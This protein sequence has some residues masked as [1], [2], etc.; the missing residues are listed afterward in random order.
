[1]HRIFLWWG[2]IFFVSLVIPVKIYASDIVLNEIFANPVNENDE[3]VELYNKSDNEIDLAGWK[4]SD[5]VK[6]YTL[7]D[8]KISPKGFLVLEKSLTGITLNNSDETVSILDNV[9]NVVDTF[10]YEDT[11]EGKTWSRVP[12]GIGDFVNNT[13]ITKGFQNAMPPTSTPSPSPTP[14]K[15]PKPTKS[16]TATKIPTSTPQPVISKIENENIDD[17]TPEP[18]IR[19]SSIPIVS[20]PRGGEVA[21]ESDIAYKA[22]D[23]LELEQEDRVPGYLYTVT[24]GIGMLVLAC[25]ILLY[26]KFKAKKE[27][28]DDF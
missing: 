27:E 2:F 17:E 13:E 10:T 9:D 5:L 1:M 21:G 14:T 4:I 24:T 18:E 16:P 22:N 6:S 20:T 12:D 3:F 19:R 26:R 25:G 23:E 15:T 7:N 8:L 11:I 28:D